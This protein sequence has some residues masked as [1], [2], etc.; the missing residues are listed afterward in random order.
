MFFSHLYRR[1]KVNG[2]FLSS[3][4]LYNH[5]NHKN[6]S[7]VSLLQIR[8]MSS[9]PPPEVL[10]NLPNIPT[11]QLFG[12]GPSN[13]PLSIQQSMDSP[14]LGHLHS[15][16][17]Q[18]MDDCKAGIKYLF[19]TNNPLTFAVSGT[20]HAGMECAIMNLLEHGESFLT[21]NNG[22][23]GTRAAGLGKRLGLNV[24]SIVVPE[25]SAASLKQIEEAI[26]QHK[27]KVLFVCQGES[28]TGVAHP[29]KGISE[30][31]HKNGAL[32]LVDTV[33]SI[34]G[35][36]F[37]A[38]AL[39]IDCVYT[40]TQKVLNAP[41]G[42]API[43]FSQKAVEKIKNRKTQCVS[44]YFDALELGNY[45]GCFG[46]P[47]RYHHTGMITMVYSLRAALAAVAKE[48]I[49]NEI[50]RHKEN[51]IYFHQKLE[52]AGF[53]LFVEDMVKQKIIESN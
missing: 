16:F 47:R 28:S 45:W 27:P 52:D 8:K 32:L 15:E 31:C 7:L 40:A 12:P 48:G 42:L 4:S 33:A 21:I 18:I 6:Y 20:G 26:I 39:G 51:M 34:G 50:N 25:G 13:M 36:E 24:Q 35:T 10:K 17:C 2:N 5:K 9:I 43:S 3:V 29:L 19:Q 38:D 14:L 44:F 22:I 41:P 37:D 53:N 30:I 46:E 49:K 1:Q 11:K 23:W